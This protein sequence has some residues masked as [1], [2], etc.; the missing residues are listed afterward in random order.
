MYEK[1]GENNKRQVIDELA[2]ESGGASR[3]TQNRGI[4]WNR[5]FIVISCAH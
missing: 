1:K 3:L 4:S 5:N 2:E